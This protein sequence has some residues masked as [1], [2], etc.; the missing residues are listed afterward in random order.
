MSFERLE[1][2]SS[3]DWRLSRSSMSSGLKPFWRARNSGKDGSTLPDRVPMTSPS[4]G[5]NPIDV[6]IGDPSRLAVAEHPLP[7]CSV[8]RRGRIA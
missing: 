2:P 5:V 7:S 6:S 4:S 1:R 8:I 3:P